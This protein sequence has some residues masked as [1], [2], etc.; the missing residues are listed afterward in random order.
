M[1]YVSTG[2]FS[3]K[4][5]YESAC[6]LFDANIFC[7]ELSGGLY[8]KNF[9]NSLIKLESKSKIQIHNYFPPPEKP[10]VMNLASNDQNI[11]KRTITHIKKAIELSSALKTYTYSFHAGFLVDPKIDELGRRVEKKLL[12]DRAKALNRFIDNVNILALYAKKFNTKLLIE[13]NVLSYNNYKH[14]GQNPFLMVDE[15]ECIEV[16]QKTE[17]NVFL[18]IDVAHLKVSSN[19]LG[20]DKLKFLKSVNSWIRAYHLS[21]NDGLSDSNHPV[22]EN[23]WFWPY[24][25]NNLD[26]YSLEVYRKNP[27]ELLEQLKLTKFMLKIDC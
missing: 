1:I 22:R 5:A 3:N 11:V 2:G 27:L 7:C 24:I 25:N 12:L 10:F 26:Y 18:L 21:D 13:N 17:K 4:T 20:F 6:D 8:D 16:M 14:F 19:S 15:N 9:E 23:S